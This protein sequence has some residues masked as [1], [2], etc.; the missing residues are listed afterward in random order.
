VRQ[1]FFAAASAAA[2][3][4]HFS[5]KTLYHI[6]NYNCSTAAALFQNAAAR[7]SNSHI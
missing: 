6:G 5:L 7:G 2:A 3:R 4:Q 1:H